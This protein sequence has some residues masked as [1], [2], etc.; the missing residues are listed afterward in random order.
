VSYRRN[1]QAGQRILSMTGVCRMAATMLSR[2]EPARRGRR[3]KASDRHPQSA[4]PAS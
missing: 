2:R 1:R 3:Q 4:I